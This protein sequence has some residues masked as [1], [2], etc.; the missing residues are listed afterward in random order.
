VPST[1]EKSSPFAF[2][3]RASCG[4]YYCGCGGGHLLGIAD[5][6]EEAARLKVEAENAKHTYRDGG[7]EYTTWPE[8]VSIERIEIGVLRPREETW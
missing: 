7:N 4:D 6:E 5:T 2:V 1:P 8:G 3:L